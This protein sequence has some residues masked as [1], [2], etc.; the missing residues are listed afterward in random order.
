MTTIQRLQKM[1]DEVIKERIKYCRKVYGERV[2]DVWSS[3]KKWFN[4]YEEWLVLNNLV[5]QF[6]HTIE[7][8]RDLQ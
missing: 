3:D 1:R 4:L 8:L 2:G 6:D 7:D 5:T